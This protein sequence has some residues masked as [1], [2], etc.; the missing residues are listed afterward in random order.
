MLSNFSFIE[1]KTKLINTLTSKFGF[2]LNLFDLAE[3]T[4]AVKNLSL[5]FYNIN[6]LKVQNVINLN[7]SWNNFLSIFIFF[8]VFF[9]VLFVFLLF[10]FF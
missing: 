10:F 9:L 3:K 1:S 4:Q 6:N 5:F 8:L 7:F 2:S